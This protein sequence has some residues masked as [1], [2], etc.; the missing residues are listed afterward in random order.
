[1]PAI[2]KPSTTTT[3]WTY[4][5]QKTLCG[6]TITREWQAST[7]T[8]EQFKNDPKACAACKKSA[9]QRNRW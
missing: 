9:T 3:H 2:I 6:L 5:G 1:M 7:Q 8:A 4:D